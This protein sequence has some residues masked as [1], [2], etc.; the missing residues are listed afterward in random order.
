MGI[1]FF[2]DM[3][4][5]TLNL[6][7]YGVYFQLAIGLLLFMI[8]SLRI[9]QGKGLFVF[10]FIVLLFIVIDTP[11]V[12]SFDTEPLK[13]LKCGYDSRIHPRDEISE[14]GM[15]F[16]GNPFVGVVC[17]RHYKLIRGYLKLKYWLVPGF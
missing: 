3:D 1:G 10:L 13:T 5:I 16:G 17:K 7:I 8:L 2:N 15:R 14:Y 11:D 12:N 6:D 9:L 4:I